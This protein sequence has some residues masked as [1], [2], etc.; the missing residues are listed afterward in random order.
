MRLQPLFSWPSMIWRSVRVIAFTLLSVG[1]A[2]A[3]DTTR[4][5][6]GVS[7]KISVRVVEWQ[8]A[9]ATF[10]DW[11]AVTGSY[12]VGPEGAVSFP[13]VGEVQAAGKTT[14]E[15]SQALSDGLRST[16]GLTDPPNVTVEVETFGPI[17]VTGDVQS[18][19]AYP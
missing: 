7:D 13:F 15:L 16:L 6:L 3:A 5:T 14:A 18:S 1:L 17:Y 8:S 11:T 19:G 9:G 4:Y 10:Q 12:L 2:G